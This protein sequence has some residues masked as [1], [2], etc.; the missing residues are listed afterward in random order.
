MILGD[1]MTEFVTTL[2]T[3]DKRKKTGSCIV[4][5]IGKGCNISVAQKDVLL[6]E[7]SANSKVGVRTGSNSCYEKF[8]ITK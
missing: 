1:A 2:S 5:S 8:K 7:L 6:G 4:D 3:F